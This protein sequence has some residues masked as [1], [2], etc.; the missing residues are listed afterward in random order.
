MWTVRELDWLDDLED[1]FQLNAP[2]RGE[3]IGVNDG[4]GG[5]EEEVWVW[6]HISWYP[7]RNIKET[8]G[9]RATENDQSWK[10]KF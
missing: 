7:H 5:L 2:K 3:V 6:S 8:V 10:Q 4:K 9:S 1:K